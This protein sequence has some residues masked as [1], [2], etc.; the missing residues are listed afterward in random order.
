MARETN[1][2]IYFPEGYPSSTEEF[3]SVRFAGFDDISLIAILTNSDLAKIIEHNPEMGFTATSCGPGYSALAIWGDFA[4]AD[5]LLEEPEA[6]VKCFGLELI[7]YIAWT[8]G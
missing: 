2:S 3:F 4:L 1:P 6:C 8:R 5:K 7:P